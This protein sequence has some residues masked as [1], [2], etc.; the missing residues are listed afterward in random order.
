MKNE[1]YGFNQQKLLK[2]DINIYE[3]C[4]L[5]YLIDS[6]MIFERYKNNPSYFLLNYD[7]IL[8]DMPILYDV[9]IKSCISVLIDWGLLDVID[10][11]NNRWIKLNESVCELMI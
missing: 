11:Y 1:I 5:R 3:A 7:L 2:M 9:N 10:D 8:S 4:I 6:H